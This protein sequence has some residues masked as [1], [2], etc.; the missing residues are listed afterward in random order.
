MHDTLHALLRDRARAAQRCDGCGWY[1]G[2]WPVLRALGLG[3]TPR[4][5]LEAY[6]GGLAGLAPQ[7]V[8]VSGAAD[9]AMAEVVVEV[10]ALQGPRPELLLV[11]RCETPLGAARAWAAERGVA[12]DVRCSDARVLGGLGPVDAVVTHSFLGYFA[13]DERPALAAAWRS[14]LRPGGRLVLVNR[15][16]PGTSEA[17]V[18]ASPEEGRRLVE[19]VL[20][21][22]GELGLDPEGLRTDLAVWVERMGAWPVRSPGEL[23]VLFTQAGFDV[24][25]QVLGGQGD[26]APGTSGQAAFVAVTATAR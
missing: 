19:R 2:L 18:G 10:C 5:H 15:L 13:P 12:L 25:L 21:G 23:E 14:V 26:P 7:R 3:S 6:R 11:D 9:P 16:R 1:H 24:T 20:A 8:L 4:R 22:A 17:W